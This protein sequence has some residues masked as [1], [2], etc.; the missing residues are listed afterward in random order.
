M[1]ERI[2]NTFH[3]YPRQFWLM[4]IG[5]FIS[6]IGAGMIW[7]FLMIYV[8]EKLGLPLRSAAMLV[9]INA[10]TSLMASFAAGSLADRF[11]RKGVMVLSLATNGLIYL[12]MSQANSYLAFAVLMFLTGASNPLY[13][14]G[15]DAMLA[16]LIPAEKRVDAYA[17]TRMITNA[18]FAIGP[19][20]GGFIASRSYA[21]AFYLAAAGMMIY[22]LLLLFRAVETLSPNAR[23]ASQQGDERWGG[24]GRVAQDRPYVFFV[25]VT[26]IGL[27]APIMLW[28]LLAVYTKQNYGILESMYGWLPTTNALMCV[29]VQ[30][31][32]TRMTRRYRPLPVIAV[33]MLVYAVGVGSV[34]LGRDFLGFW[35]SMVVTTFGELII[36]PTAST[37]VANLAPADM[38]GRYMSMYWLAWSISS[39]VGP[40]LGGYLN[41]AIRPQAIWIGGLLIGLVS[42][43][44]L[45]ALAYRQRKPDL[46]VD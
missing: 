9:T 21:L 18:G 20:I 10:A 26:G 31:S 15:A 43:V 2:R 30:Y 8:S 42:T 33:G 46:L 41:D 11:G 13:R 36:V 38:R 28:V 3:A 32:V 39:A 1:L 4:F 7:P 45:A 19:A 27:I 44:G 12:F 37:Y 24:Y 17:L 23:A 5:M 16:D 34:A 40:V 29:F 25:L 14:V 35:V 6:T 22:S